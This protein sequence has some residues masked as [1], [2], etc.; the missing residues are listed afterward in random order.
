[1]REPQGN[2]IAE[3]FVRILKENLL[4]VRSFDTVEELRL[5]LL[6]FKDTYN[7]QWRIGRHGLVSVEA[8]HDD[9]ALVCNAVA[10]DGHIFG[11]LDALTKLQG[12]PLFRISRAGNLA[13]QV[14]PILQKDPVF[15]HSRTGQRGIGVFDVV[16]PPTKPMPSFLKQSAVAV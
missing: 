8:S 1:M 12:L 3:R 5:A 6:A 10:G 11:G 15:L 4:W 7:R 14:L 2:G 13:V 9:F 16:M